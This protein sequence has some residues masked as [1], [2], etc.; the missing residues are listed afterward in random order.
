MCYRTDFPVGSVDDQLA[1]Y[2]NIVFKGLDNAIFL[3][4]LRVTGR[5]K[6]MYYFFLYLLC[7]NTFT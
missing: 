4:K 1:E 3:E 7:F 6:G 5:V 2:R